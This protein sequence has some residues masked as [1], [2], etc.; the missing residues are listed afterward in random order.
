MKS[1]QALLA[2]ALVLASGVT[3][4]RAQTTYTY[5]GANNGTWSAPANWTPNTSYPGNG[6]A[7]GNTDIALINSVAANQNINYD[8]AASGFLGTLTINE[9]TAGVTNQVT[10]QR[11]LTLTNALSLGASAGTAQIAIGGNILTDAAGINVSAGGN[12]TASS[13]TINGNLNMT[14]GTINASNLVL[15]GATNSI[16]GVTTGSTIANLTLASPG[17]N[18]TLALGSGVSLTGTLTIKTGGAQQTTTVSSVSNLSGSINLNEANNFRFPTLQLGSNLTANNITATSGATASTNTN[19]FLIDVNSNT[20]TLTNAAG[21]TATTTNTYGTV[22]TPVVVSWI[23][24]DSGTGGVFQAPSFNLSPTAQ[25]NFTNNGVTVQGDLTLQATGG[26]GTANVLSNTAGTISATST[27]LY[28]GNAAAATPATLAS[29]RAIGSLRVQNGAL[30][31][32]TAITAAGANVA[33]TNGG[34]LDLHAFNLAA[35]SAALTLSDTNGTSGTIINSTAATGSS[36]VTLSAASMTFNPGG[37]LTYT[38]S[39]TDNTAN[40]L[41]SLTGSFTKGTIGTG[42]YTLNFIGGMVGQTYDLVN[43]GSNGGFSASDFTITGTAGTLSFNGGELD[44]T[45]GAVPEP[46]T[47]AAVLL[48]VGVVLFATRRSL[49]R[50]A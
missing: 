19:R 23:L 25:G 46:S 34:T 36:R 5:A 43:F 49:R 38:L 14:G 20:L 37:M 33:V 32:S 12:L 17:V 16:G 47:W 1:S 30:Q 42:L 13:G 11:S 28:S 24:N 4:L 8:S 21:F 10:L 22:T 6:G 26:N 7:A 2:G 40:M 44:F 31:L 27:F 39:N 3:S 18:Q 50:A 41:I 45:V 15:G 48:S 35:T 9:A 29:N